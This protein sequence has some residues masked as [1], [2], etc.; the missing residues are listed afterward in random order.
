MYDN[1]S[2]IGSFKDS[3]SRFR[4]NFNYETG[5]WR[6]Y[7]L[8]HDDLAQYSG[9]DDDIPDT[10]PAVTILSEGMFNAVINEAD[11]LGILGKLKNVTPEQDDKVL[12]EIKQI[13]EELQKE[14]LKVDKREYTE[15][16]LLR[17]RIIEANLRLASMDSIEGLDKIE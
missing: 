12:E 1:V 3:L 7:D 8:W 16:Y 17:S 10:S 4:A 6:I 11:R 9:L 5:V 2:A 15:R 13:K 14:E